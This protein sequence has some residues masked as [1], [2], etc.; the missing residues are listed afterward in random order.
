MRGYQSDWSIV[1]IF[2]KP[3]FASEFGDR[4]LKFPLLLMA[5]LK[6]SAIC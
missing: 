5:S 6:F 4:E 2:F 3:Y 1:R